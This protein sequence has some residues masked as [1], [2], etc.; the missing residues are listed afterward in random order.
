MF[1]TVSFHGSSQL[2]SRC[3]GRGWIQVAGSASKQWHSNRINVYIYIYIYIYIQLNDHCQMA[4][5]ADQ[6]FVFQRSNAGTPALQ[7]YFL[8][9]AP[10]STTL[11]FGRKAFAKVESSCNRSSLCQGRKLLPAIEFTATIIFGRK[12][13]VKVNLT[14]LTTQRGYIGGQQ[15]TTRLRKKW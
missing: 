11:L 2:G 4:F 13:W 12:A 5:T 7:H 3:D 6:V 15:S 1:A 10:P 14:D 8:T 9:Y